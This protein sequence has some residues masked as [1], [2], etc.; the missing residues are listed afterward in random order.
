MDK[1]K[2]TEDSLLSAARRYRDALRTADTL[3]ED[4]DT[5]NVQDAL[6]RLK[7]AALKL[8]D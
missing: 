8:E 7:T 4:P 6:E 1:R 5:N 2:T 3:Y